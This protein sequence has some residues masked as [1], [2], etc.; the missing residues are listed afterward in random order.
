MLRLLPKLFR[1]ACLMA[2]PSLLPIAEAGAK[3]APPMTI[4]LHCEGA[5]SDGSSFVTEL[6]L[7]DGSKLPI[8]KVPVVN[9]RDITAFYPFPGN[10]GLAG[11]YFRLD[12]HGSNKLHQLG[13]E[14]KG[15]T[16][17]ILLNGR[18]ASI[19]KISGTVSDGILYVPGGILPQ[20]V[21]QLEG[22]FPVIGRESEFGK[23]KR[24]PKAQPAS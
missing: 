18:P 9:E 13:V 14:D 23:T 6:T 24:Q 5:A 1:Y 7:T 20:E 4:R 21:L 10:D 12:A 22:H 11:A 17:V 2:L 3:K 15:R 19:L 16:A 8:R